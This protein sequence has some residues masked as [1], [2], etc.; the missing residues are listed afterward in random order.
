MSTRDLARI[1]IPILIII[2]ITTV[3]V[4][5]ITNPPSG[6]L[7]CNLSSAKGDPHAEYTYKVH[8][9]HW[10]VNSIET[11]EVITSKNQEKL[12]EFE[13]EKQKTKKENKSDKNYHKKMVLKKGSL[14]TITT[15]QY[16]DL[17]IKKIKKMYQTLGAKCKY[18]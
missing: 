1:M 16:K 2:M 6:N 15:V 12:K 4:W 18:K 5:L 8:F 17:K 9:K 7:V 14:K 3:S 13:Q 11:T 10:K